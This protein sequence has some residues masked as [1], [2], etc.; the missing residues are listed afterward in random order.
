MITEE[1]RKARMGGIG[2][3]DVAA[4]L[5]ISPWKTPVDIWLEKKGLADS[6]A[7]QSEAIWWGNE[8]EA[9]VAKR[10]TELTRLKTVNYN[11]TISD[12]CLLANIDRLIIPDGQSIA[13]HKREIRTNQFLEIKTSGCEWDEAPIVENINGCNVLDG[14]IAVPPHYCAQIFHYFGRMPSAEKAYVAVKAAIPFGRFSRTEFNVY[15]LR[16][17]QELIDE[18]DA[19]ARGWWEKYIVGDRRPEATNEDEAKKLW[20][21]SKP[22]ST[23]VAVPD[24]LLAWRDYRAAKEMLKDAEAAVGAAETK[25]RNAMKE[26]EALVGSD[27]KTVLATWKSAKDRVSQ[28]TDWERIA[29][30]KGVTDDEIKA[31]TTTVTKP[32]NRSFLVKSSASVVE[33]AQKEIARIEAAKELAASEP[34]KAEKAA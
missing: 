16:R 5:G 19:F 28:V 26:A 8:E 33:F 34:N 23:T 25:I 14:D 17:D 10:F 24:V 1:Q 15:V 12:G 21:V 13:A 7:I 9:L 6:S 22:G 32:G 20:R 2:G 27:G 11:F 31:A 18:Q 30:D 4:I 3:S 29:R